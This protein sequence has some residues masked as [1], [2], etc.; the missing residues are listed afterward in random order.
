[1]TEPRRADN[2]RYH[3]LS[4]N[5]EARTRR[6]VAWDFMRGLEVNGLHIAAQSNDPEAPA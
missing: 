3:G 5:L 4:V 1:M 2:D 6:L